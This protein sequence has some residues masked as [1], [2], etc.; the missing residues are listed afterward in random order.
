M[1]G[2]QF[3]VT[4]ADRRL[5]FGGR[6]AVT[7]SFDPLTH[8]VLLES[9]AIVEVKAENGLT[10]TKVGNKLWMGISEK[11]VLVEAC[12]GREGRPSSG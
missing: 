6:G 4:N 5:R 7:I 1:K 2:Y 8:T 3:S 9:P 10:A 11:G 12:R